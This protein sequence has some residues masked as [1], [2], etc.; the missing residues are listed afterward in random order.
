MKTLGIIVF[1][2]IL[3]PFL[4]VC[5]LASGI[6]LGVQDVF[7]KVKTNRV[8]QQKHEDPYSSWMDS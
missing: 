8:E 4:L 1:A 6:Y 3:S 5:L 7:G 2:C